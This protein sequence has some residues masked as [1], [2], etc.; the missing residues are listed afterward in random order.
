MSD[1]FRRPLTRPITR[2][3]ALGVWQGQAEPCNEADAVKTLNENLAKSEALRDKLTEEIAVLTKEIDELEAALEKTT[4]ERN[5]ESAENAA[6]IS[7]AQEGQAAVEQAIG[8]LEKFY[9]TAAKAE[10]LVQVSSKQV[11]DMPDA[12]FEGANKGS[13]SAC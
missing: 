13:Q 3:G 6:T 4:K 8:V 2:A 9:K 5:D 1:C 7:E 12:G 11:P 10:V